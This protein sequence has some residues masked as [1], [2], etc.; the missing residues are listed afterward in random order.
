MRKIA[1]T[2]TIGAGKTS[3]AIMIRRRGMAVFNCD[4]YARL[5]TNRNNPC[6]AP[7][8]A[9]F[10]EQIINSTGD[11]DRSKLAAE[12]FADEEKRLALNAVTHPYIREGMHRFFESHKDDAFVFAE[13]PL[14]FEAGFETDFDIVLCVTC[15]K[16]TAVKRLMEDREYTREQALARYDS[17]IDPEIQKARADRVIENNGTLSDLDRAINLWIGEMR[18]GKA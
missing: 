8:V 7:I 10:G 13:V 17:Q 2:G 15:D 14:L 5:C 6:F 11:I 1:I 16:E 12:V 9:I 18:R 3:A 4:Q